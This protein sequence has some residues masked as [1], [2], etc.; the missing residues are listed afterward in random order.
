M[1]VYIYIYYIYIYIE[2]EREYSKFSP[3]KC[4]TTYDTCPHRLPTKGDSTLSVDNAVLPH[5]LHKQPLPPNR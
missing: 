5:W 4:E 1:Y 2:R 3:T